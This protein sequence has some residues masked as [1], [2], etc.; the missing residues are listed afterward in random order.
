MLP[1]LFALILPLANCK[2]GAEETPQADTDPEEQIILAYLFGT[3]LLGPN[4]IF[5]N[6]AATIEQCG[7][8]TVDS[9]AACPIL[10]SKGEEVLAKTLNDNLNLTLGINS[11]GVT[12]RMYLVAPHHNTGYFPYELQVA[13]NYRAGAEYQTNIIT[14]GQTGETPLIGTANGFNLQLV[15]F[16]AEERPNGMKGQ[17]TVLLSSGLVTGATTLIYNFDSEQ[18]L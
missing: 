16:R 9:L 1:L 18:V 11:S 12:G 6:G 17:F 3:G 13:G 10:I 8:N 14:L 15:E 2:S 5:W 4:G 7:G